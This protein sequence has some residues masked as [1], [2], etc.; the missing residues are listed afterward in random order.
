MNP[1]NFPERKHARQTEAAARNLAWNSLSKNSQIAILKKR[2]GK[3]ERQ[4]N[5]I[6]NKEG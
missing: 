5:R 6:L 1:F 3:C 4:L 2:P